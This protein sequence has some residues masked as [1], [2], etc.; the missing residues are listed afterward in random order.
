[1]PSLQMTQFDS[2]G[3]PV[4]V[5]CSQRVVIDLRRIQP[6]FYGTEEVSKEV[7]RQINALSLNIHCTNDN[8]RL[9]ATREGDPNPDVEETRIDPTRISS[10]DNR[11]KV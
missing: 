1:V 2:I 10:G 11:N 6:A 8:D 5:I 4:L 9:F 7:N 3:L